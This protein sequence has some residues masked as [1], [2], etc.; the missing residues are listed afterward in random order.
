MYTRTRGRCYEGKMF[1]TLCGFADGRLGIDRKIGGFFTF[2]VPAP[3]L[4][5]DISIY[6]TAETSNSRRPVCIAPRFVSGP[7]WVP[8]RIFSRA[9]FRTRRESG[10]GTVAR[11]GN[12][13]NRAKPETRASGVGGTKAGKSV[14]VGENA[15]KTRSRGH[16]HETAYAYI[17]DAGKHMRAG[18][19]HRE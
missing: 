4:L 14:R 1:V 3:L 15:K 8:G 2:L 10:G 11:L 17:H 6:A 9:R 12:S 19:A 18:A 13:K 7:R 5:R 16:L